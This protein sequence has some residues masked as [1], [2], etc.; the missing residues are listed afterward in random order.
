MGPNRSKHSKKA[1][2]CQF[3][4]MVTVAESTVVGAW[5]GPGSEGGQQCEPWADCT[6]WGGP[7]PCVRVFLR[8]VSSKSLCPRLTIHT[9]V[10]AELGAL[11]PPRA[12]V[13]HGY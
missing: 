4:V 10:S 5:K 11:P 7:A 9:I 1:V 13:H 6:W 2:Q 3:M 8:S 12:K